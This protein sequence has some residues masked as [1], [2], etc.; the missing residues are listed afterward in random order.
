M[1]RVQFTDQALE[2][3]EEILSFLRLS[4][5]ED[6]VLQ[7]GKQLLEQAESLKQYPYKGQK[8]EQLQSIGLG[9]RR[10]VVDH[11]KVIYRVTGTSIYIIDFFDTRQ[12]PHKMYPH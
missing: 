4:M 1:K 2:R 12:D 3:L 9:H 7:V 8:E 5:P 6:A 11:Y 10:L